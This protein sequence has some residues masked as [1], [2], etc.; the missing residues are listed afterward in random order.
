[1]ETTNGSPVTSRRSW[2][3]W[4][5]AWRMLMRVILGAALGH[6]RRWHSGRTMPTQVVVDDRVPVRGA[7]VRRHVA[8]AR[9]AA[10]EDDHVGSA[11]AAC[12]DHGNVVRVG[13]PL[14]AESHPAR[15]NGCCNSE[16]VRCRQCGV[17]AF[18]DHSSMR[19]LPLGEGQRSR[20]YRPHPSFE[21]GY[22]RVLSTDEAAGGCA[23]NEDEPCEQRRP[24]P[25][26]ASLRTRRRPGR[27]GPLGNRRARSDRDNPTTSRLLDR[28]GQE[29]ARS[30]RELRVDQ[31]E[32][33]ADRAEVG[34]RVHC[35]EP[36]P[37]PFEDFLRGVHAD[38]LTSDS[39]CSGPGPGGGP[40]PFLVE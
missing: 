29:H 1:M 32:L 10:A 13:R 35:A 25:A 23:C 18:S 5:A 17:A 2:P 26:A 27:L 33:R 19:R 39:R 22:R 30:L 9:P 8:V 14:P 37:R 7:R 24:A 34:G 4:Q 36:C 12:P 16:H 40:A 20:G 21:P 38:S 11:R 3:Q 15:A 31:R 28:A 6:D